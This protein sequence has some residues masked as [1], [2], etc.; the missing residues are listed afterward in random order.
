[1]KQLPE[2]VTETAFLPPSPQLDAVTR[3]YC[4]EGNLTQTLCYDFLFAVT[5]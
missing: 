1:M 5:G 4:S 2:A 3:H